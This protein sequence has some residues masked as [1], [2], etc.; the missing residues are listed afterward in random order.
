LRIAFVSTSYPT[1][2]GDPSGHFVRAEATW[3]AAQ[4]HDVHVIAPRPLSSDRGVSVHAAGGGAL[5]AWPGAH[6]RAAARPD[7][8]LA[9]G[10]FF[11]RARRALERLAPD[12]TVAHWMVPSAFPIGISS[13][14]HGELEVVCHG[15]DVRLLLAA[16]AAA[17]DAV[18]ARVC[19]RACRVRLVASALL[20][21]LLRALPAA[22]ALARERIAVVEPPRVDTTA[23]GE[24]PEGQ[25]AY[26][27]SVGRLVRSKRV[28]VAIE[29]LAA[30]PSAPR[31]VI[32]GDGPELAALRAL[33][34]RR[35]PGRVCF[36]GQ[37]PRG[38]ALGW[39]R[40]AG[41]LLHPSEAEAAPTVVLEALSLGVSVL[42]CDAGD[43]G[44][45]AA[46]RAGLTLSPR[47]PAA[48]AG[49]LARLLARPVPGP[50][51]GP[52]PSRPR[53]P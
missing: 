50:F 14:N 7:R 52:D 48:M 10:P 12:R 5:F 21:G 11:L 39:I 23:A 43:L 38:E 36:L 31:L 24:A 34:A 30:C 19:G 37:L 33:A 22:T 49:H 40:G 2:P 46:Q 45:W 4:G 16:P 17:R 44:R 27:A 35:A 9:A 18:V 28:D 1:T 15:A 47:E 53:S 42:A 20:D 6:A 29:A 51:S 8:L 32:I 13:R 26:L 3:S 25:G 41:A